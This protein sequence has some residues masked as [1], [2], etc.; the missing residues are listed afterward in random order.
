[1]KYIIIIQLPKTLK[2][3]TYYKDDILRA[4]KDSFII[5]NK[6][7]HDLGNY[8]NEDNY[9]DDVYNIFYNSQ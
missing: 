8:D 9:I 4:L 6:K 2:E 7:L 5:T 3:Q 1:M